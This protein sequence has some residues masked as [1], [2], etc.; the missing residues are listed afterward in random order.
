MCRIRAVDKDM[1]DAY[2]INNGNQRDVRALIVLSLAFC[3]NAQQKNMYIF[4]FDV[5]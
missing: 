3:W 1:K 5:H 2:L 4:S